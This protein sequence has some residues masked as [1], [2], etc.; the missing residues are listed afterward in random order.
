MH[1]KYDREM[2]YPWI[3]DDTLEIDDVNCYLHNEILDYVKWLEPS[4]EDK[5]ARK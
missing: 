5:D 1:S 3:T 2:N 4:D